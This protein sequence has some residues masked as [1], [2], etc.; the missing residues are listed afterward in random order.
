MD[1]IW[2]VLQAIFIRGCQSLRVNCAGRKGHGNVGQ[3]KHHE[4][5]EP[6]L[7]KSDLH[8]KEEGP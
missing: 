7:G 5:S 4:I 8:G 6:A 1:K 2:E 3:Q